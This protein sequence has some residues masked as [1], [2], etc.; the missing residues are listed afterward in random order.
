MDRKI[1]KPRPPIPGSRARRAASSSSHNHWVTAF[2]RA[3]LQPKEVFMAKKTLFA[4]SVAVVLVL[5]PNVRAALSWRRVAWWRL[6]RRRLARRWMGLGRPGYWDWTWPRARQRSGLGSWL[7]MG[8]WLGR[9]WLR[10]VGRLHEVASRLDRL[11]MAGCPSER[12]LV[13]RNDPAQ[14]RSDVVSTGPARTSQ[15]VRPPGSPR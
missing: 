12:L 11:G 2:N 5:T 10:R 8:A 3:S 13:S 7:G 9:S 14:K 15:A 1:V 4:L 6:A